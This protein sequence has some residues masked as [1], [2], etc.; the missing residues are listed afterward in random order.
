MEAREFRHA[1]SNGNP[2]QR[3]EHVKGRQKEEGSGPDDGKYKYPTGR[4][5]A[6]TS[7]SFPRRCGCGADGTG[8]VTL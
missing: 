7:R 8:F 1:R 6:V 5:L 4:I 3:L 2:Q